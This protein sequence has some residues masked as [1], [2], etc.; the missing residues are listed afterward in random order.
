MGVITKEVETT[1]AATTVDY[2]KEKGYYIPA[3]IASDGKKKI[4]KVQK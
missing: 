3:Y 4:K 2:Y 1:I